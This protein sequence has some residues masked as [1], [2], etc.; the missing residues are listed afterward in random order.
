L[1]DADFQGRPRKLLALAS[2]SGYYFLLDRA[3][4]ESLLT[5]PYGGQNWSQGVDGRGQPIPKPEQDQTE[6]GV[7]FEGSTT[8]WWAPSFDPE[9]RLLY[10]NATHG[11]SVGYL[12]PDNDEDQVEDHQG[13]GSTH[14]W[15][16][17]TLLALDYQT[18]KPRWTRMSGRGGAAEGRGNGILTTAGHLLFTNESS[19][20]VALDPAGGKVLWHVN[21]GGELTGS[22]MT[23]EL[24]GRQYVI[25]PVDGVLYAWALPADAR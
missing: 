22:P 12:T 15:G 23:Y 21:A 17:S 8:N 13:G 7:F 16:E 6:D 24:E 5:V 1:F 18:G 14:L 4:G 19:Q 25:T 11:F 2:R 10:V 9:T 20:L 3:T